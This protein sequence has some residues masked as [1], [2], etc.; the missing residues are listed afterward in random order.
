MWTPNSVYMW[1][2]FTLLKF[3][4]NRIR[5]I[6]H[7]WDARINNLC[8][9]NGLGGSK[10]S[11]KIE[12]FPRATKG[13][14]NSPNGKLESCTILLGPNL[15]SKRKTLNN[16]LH[17]IRSI[18]KSKLSIRNNKSV[19]REPL[20]KAFLALWHANLG[21]CQTISSPIYS[22]F[23]INPPPSHNS[24]RSLYGQPLNVGK[25][26]WSQR[27]HAKRSPPYTSYTY[28]FPPVS[29]EVV[30]LFCFSNSERDF[31]ILWAIILTVVE[32]LRTENL[33]QIKSYSFHLYHNVRL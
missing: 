1:A 10:R 11:G 8:R 4:I 32:E 19:L 5:Y 2:V 12:K 30:Y 13:D 3:N 14:E 15:K 26:N 17:D 18:F 25:R 23:S 16:R 29:N 22:R 27:V 28:D 33:A 24:V 7:R 31:G 21:K 6:P 20:F 9:W